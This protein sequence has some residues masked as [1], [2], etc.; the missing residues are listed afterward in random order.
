LDS[1]EEG[2]PRLSLPESFPL[3]PFLDQAPISTP[4]GCSPHCCHPS[5]DPAWQRLAPATPHRPGRHHGRRGHPSLG[6]APPTV[7]RPVTSPPAPSRINGS[8]PC[9]R[10][11]RDRLCTAG[12]PCLHDATWPPRASRACT[13]FPCAATS[14]SPALLARL[15]GTVTPPR[16]HPCL[17]PWCTE[18]TASR[19]VLL[20]A[21]LKPHASQPDPAVT[22]TPVCFPAL[23]APCRLTQPPMAAN[24]ERH[25]RTIDRI[26][27]SV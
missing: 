20:A 11:P 9:S 19:T 12:Q 17:A 18:S 4:S 15:Q 3:P 7:P 2:S 22:D 24:G 27:L 16:C 26:H 6:S 25:R 23:S 5:T 13:P 1:R 14:P 21:S 10:K 8:I